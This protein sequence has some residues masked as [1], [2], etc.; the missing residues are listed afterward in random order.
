MNVNRKD[1]HY[2]KVQKLLWTSMKLVCRFLWKIGLNFVHACA[3]HTCKYGN[4]VYTVDKTRVSTVI[5]HVQWSPLSSTPV[6]SKYIILY[7]IRRTLIKSNSS[8]Y[9]LNVLAWTFIMLGVR[10]KRGPRWFEHFWSIYHQ[11]GNPFYD[12]FSS[13]DAYKNTYK[14]HSRV[15]IQKFST[16]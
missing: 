9:L 3:L 14:Q 11:K 16:L 4:I 6:N 8:L 1:V 7:A 2:P 5:S 15:K 12:L 13:S 10:A